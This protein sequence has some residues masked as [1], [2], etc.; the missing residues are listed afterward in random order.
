MNYNVLIFLFLF[1]ATW[2]L[3]ARAETHD[4]RL[5]EMDVAELLR[6][7]EGEVVAVEPSEL[8]E[9]YQVALKIQ[10]RIIPVY[11]HSSGKYLFSGNII[12]I[13]NRRNL[14][15]EH[16]RA[17]N[18][19]ETAQ[20]PVDEGLSLGKP[21]AAQQLFVFTDPN[22][23]FCGKL[24]QVLIEAVEADPSLAFHI[25]LTPLKKHSY[26]IAKTIICNQ[27]LEQLDQA[28]SGQ[29]LTITTCDSDR[30]EDN[31]ALAEK[32][33]IRGTPTL[34]LPNGRVAPGYR[35]LKELLELIDANRLKTENQLP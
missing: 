25:K 28:F 18:P 32:L 19:V 5:T 13:Q 14:T 35:P 34:I 17:L 4:A 33:G 9:F 29:A 15:E 23:P 21:D 30:I 31:L 6:D 3:Q 16:F 10:G 12:D 27:S 24:H 22:C 1:L 26:D 20:I 11:L 8:S 7:I 2:P